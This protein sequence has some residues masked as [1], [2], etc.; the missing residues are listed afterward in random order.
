MVAAPG[1]SMA[2][3]LLPDSN[4]RG[5]W[6][7]TLQ[8]ELCPWGKAIS[9]SQEASFV[10]LKV[11]MTCEESFQWISKTGEKNPCEQQKQKGNTKRG[12]RKEVTAEKRNL[13]PVQEHSSFFLQR[14]TKYVYFLYFIDIGLQY[15]LFFFCRM[16]SVPIFIPT[17]PH[18]HMVCGIAAACV[19]CHESR[20]P[21]TFKPLTVRVRGRVI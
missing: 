6:S 1:P 19:V 21:N 5:L 14:Y 2:P 7:W 10:K 9:S 17:K 18:I 8:I 3:C 16:L 15:F 13:D 12:K 11:E 20:N 4:A